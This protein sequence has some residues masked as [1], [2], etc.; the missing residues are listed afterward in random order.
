ME[1]ELE[2]TDYLNIMKKHWFLALISFILVL[3]A[4]V[5]YT[6]IIPPIYEAKTLLIVNNQDQAN[7]LLGSSAPKSTDLETQRIII[8][9]PMI[10]APIYEEHGDQSFVLSVTN[11]KNS[12]ILELSVQSNNPESAV[13]IA[14]EVALNY[15]N[16]TS[17]SRTK[18]AENNIELITEKIDTYQDEISLIEASIKYY[19]DNEIF[20]NKAEMESYASLQKELNAKNKIYDYLLTKREEATL[21]ANL[22]TA[23][24]RVLQYAEL[25]E[26]PIKPNKQLN[27]ALGVILGLAAALGAAMIANN[28]NSKH[29]NTY[30]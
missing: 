12:N 24:V 14:N 21:A 7:F 4:V 3:G 11:I 25:P 18:D 17:D 16:Y 26:F 9:S 6:E 22:R 5:V 8:Q 10:L 29:G 13:I 28:S 1:E 23:N 2:F 30:Y 19:K 15:I 20:L 27:F